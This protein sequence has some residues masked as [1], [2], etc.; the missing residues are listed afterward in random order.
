MFESI[1]V[2]LLGTWQ[3]HVVKDKDFWHKIDRDTPVEY[4]ATVTINPLTALR[5]IEDYVDLK[6]GAKMSVFIITF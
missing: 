2:F 1:K 6:S 4:A 3:T 5:M